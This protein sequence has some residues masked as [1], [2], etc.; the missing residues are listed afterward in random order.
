LALNDIKSA[1][2]SPLSSHVYVKEA[3][4]LSIITR[5]INREVLV[6]AL[7]VSMVLLLIISSSR[8]AHYLSKAV[9]GELDAQAVVEIIIN[10]LPAYL[11]TLLPLG[12]F[13]AVLLTLGRLSVDNELTVLFANGVSQAQLVKAVL[14]PLSILALLVAFLSL[15]LAPE[16]SRNVEQV[17]YQQSHEAEFDSVVAGRFQGNI[18]RQVIYAQGMS[19]DR[20][21]LQ[22]VFVFNRPAPGA[23]PV[24]IKSTS[25]RQVFGATLLAGIV[26]GNDPYRE[27]DRHCLGSSKPT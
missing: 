16:T 11:S 12:G 8:F 2:L 10:L 26:T 27:F 3:V 7:A 1:T 17:L 6:S 25:A 14:V 18:E 5:Y 24:V 19:D 4:T 13:L 21:Q 15:W 9:T 22:N 20:Q 23:A